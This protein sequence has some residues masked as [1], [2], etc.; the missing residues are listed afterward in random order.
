MS[1]QHRPIVIPPRRLLGIAVVCTVVGLLLLSL[2]GCSL[3]KGGKALDG[4]VIG[5]AGVDYHSTRLA[6]QSG[7][8]IEGNPLVGSGAIRQ[9]LVKSLGA[10][11]VIAGAFAIEERGHTV[12]S[13]ILR[14]VAIVAWTT[15]S[16]HNYK[17]A[18]MR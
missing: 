5:S 8:G 11:L 2:I 16:I 7:H 14:G 9:A 1:E 4:G 13:Q 12:W 15:A 18:G 10:G 6:I 17:L 3:S